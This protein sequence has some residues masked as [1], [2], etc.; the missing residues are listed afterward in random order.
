MMGKNTGNNGGTIRATEQVLPVGVLLGDYEILSPLYRSANCIAYLAI[1]A[2]EQQTVVLR[3]FFPVPHV[4]R[5]PGGYGVV[6][7][8]TEKSAL[9]ERR[10]L[11][12]LHKAHC[13]SKVKHPGVLSVQRAFAALGTVYTVQPYDHSPTLLQ[14]APAPE[15]VTEAWLKAR[16]LKLLDALT[17]LHGAGVLH[18]S[19]TLDNILMRQDGSPVI[20][21]PDDSRE[22]P[23][24]HA[25][26]ALP[27]LCYRPLELLQAKLPVGPW[28]DMYSLGGICYRLITGELPPNSIYRSYDGVPYRPLA[29][30]PELVG[31]YSREFLSTIDR[32]MEIWP[33][34]R[35]QN[36]AEWVQALNGESVKHRSRWWGCTGAVLLISV[37]LILLLYA[38]IQWGAGDD[39][40]VWLSPADM[41][42]PVVCQSFA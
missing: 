9:A 4:E 42:P 24:E 17:A 8:G 7:A 16:L 34:D 30:C 5:E 21:G 19:L 10:R 13:L 31:R 1:N 12:F 11:D 15:M 27:T 41:A 32:A 40:A 28:S 23:P 26:D 39:A 14:A 38:L 18:K 2:Q 25:A 35:W 20:I 29:E 36:I 37:L 33:Q 3:E 22:T 6:P